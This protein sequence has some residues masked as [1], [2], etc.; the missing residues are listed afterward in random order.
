MNTYALNY[1][2]KWVIFG[3]TKHY[4]YPKFHKGHSVGD[5]A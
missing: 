3:S 1:C 5:I 2:K 4:S